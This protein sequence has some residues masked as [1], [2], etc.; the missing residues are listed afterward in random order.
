MSRFHTTLRPVR[1]TAA[2][3]TSLAL[4]L[5]LGLAAAVPAAAAGPPGDEA[6]PS[7]AAPLSHLGELLE[8]LFGFARPGVHSAGTGDHGPGM[9]PDGFEDEGDHGPDM[10]PDGLE[11]EGD[12]GPD[13]D[14]DG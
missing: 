2:L 1:R 7:S 12:H 9:D 8:R 13:M 11:N 6:R 3:V 4:A 14:P 10:D 5:L